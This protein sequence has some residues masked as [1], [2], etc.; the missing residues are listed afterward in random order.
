MSRDFRQGL[1][2]GLWAALCLAIIAPT[3]TRAQLE[4]ERLSLR[5]CNAKLRNSEVAEIVV[6]ESN[7]WTTTL[8]NLEIRSTVTLSASASAGTG[9]QLDARD[10]AISETPR[11][12]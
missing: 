1:T 8:S 12:I 10:A 11:L 2:L 9:G 4:A 7:L 3:D 6:T 5:D